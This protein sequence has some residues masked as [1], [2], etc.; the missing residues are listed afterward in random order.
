MINVL[1]N[2]LDLV[3]EI[4]INTIEIEPKNKP[5]YNNLFKLIERKRRLHLEQEL[6]LSNSRRKYQSPYL[7]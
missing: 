7:V 4:Y 1:P 3:A 5:D 6:E 2:E